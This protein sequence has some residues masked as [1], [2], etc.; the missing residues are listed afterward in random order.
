MLDLIRWF[1]G[2]RKSK[3][4]A[5][6][7]RVLGKD[8]CQMFDMK[9]VVPDTTPKTSFKK[10]SW[11]KLNTLRYSKQSVE[12]TLKSHGILKKT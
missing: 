8:K 9:I 7:R 12:S 10:F 5:E 2:T 4:R 6:P 11:P 3:V 1:I